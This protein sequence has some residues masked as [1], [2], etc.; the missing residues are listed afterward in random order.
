[1]VQG[2]LKEEYT[3]NYYEVEGEAG[4]KVD[5]EGQSYFELDTAQVTV[6]IAD[7][8]AIGSLVHGGEEDNGQDA[9]P[10]EQASLDAAASGPHIDGS[11]YYLDIDGNTGSSNFAVFS[12]NDGYTAYAVHDDADGWEISRWSQNYE[13]DPGGLSNVQELSA[14]TV[15]DTPISYELIPTPAEHI[16]DGPHI[17]GN[18]YH[19]DIDGNTG[20]SNFAAFSNNDGYTAYEVHDAGAGWE[21]SK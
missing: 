9:T 7:L 6:A 3:F 5:P 20:S 18:I 14:S 15:L 19:L 16:V 17:D 21:I 8:E 11:I 2:T 4:Y 1:M 10:N 12:N 13:A